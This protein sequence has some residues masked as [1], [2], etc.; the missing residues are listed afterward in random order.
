MREHTGSNK[1]KKMRDTIKRN[2]KGRD[3]LEM[4]L[5]RNLRIITERQWDNKGAGQGRIGA[6]QN[7]CVSGG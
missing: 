7:N 2:N 3:D 6:C 5:T 4:N 1:R